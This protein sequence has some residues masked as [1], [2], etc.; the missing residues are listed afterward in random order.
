MVRIAYAIDEESTGDNFSIEWSA[1]PKK[2]I[3]NKDV[4]IKRE[5]NKSK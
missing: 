4:R 2:S 1:L 5:I 3:K